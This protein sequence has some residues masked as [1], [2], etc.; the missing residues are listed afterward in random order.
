VTGAN[1]GSGASIKTDRNNSVIPASGS[2]S[3]Y[4]RLFNARH[5]FTLPRDY[6]LTIAAVSR[7]WDEGTGLDMEAYSDS[8]SANWS[9]AASSSSGVINWTNTG[10]DFHTTP[11]FSAYVDKGPDDLE[12]E[13]TWLVEEWISGS[14]AGAGG[15]TLGKENEGVGIYLTNESAYSSSYTKKLN[16][17]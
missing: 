4:L 6:N 2:V 17:L 15:S 12:V 1:G 5:P 8:G 14:G 3:F 13:I 10:G 16:A 11:K 9:S 7:S